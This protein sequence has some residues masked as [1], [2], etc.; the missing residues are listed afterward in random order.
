[1]AGALPAPEVLRQLEGY[2]SDPAIARTG[3]LLLQ[4]TQAGGGGGAD[5]VAAIMGLPSHEQLEYSCFA[6]LCHACAKPEARGSKLLRCGACGVSSYCSAAC[7]KADWKAGHKG[8]CKAL[9]ESRA[10]LAAAAAAVP[11][12]AAAAAANA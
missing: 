4:M 11:A 9:G 8:A 2:S 12:A 7:Q 3:A 1:M 5:G 6:K 10:A